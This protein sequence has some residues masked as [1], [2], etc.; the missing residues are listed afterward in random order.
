MCAYVCLCVCRNVRVYMCLSVC[1]GVCVSM[2][3]CVYVGVSNACE[4]VGE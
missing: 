3:A 4:C 1:G 2:S